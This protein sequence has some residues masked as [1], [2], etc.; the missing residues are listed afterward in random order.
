MNGFIKSFFK[1]T[2]LILLSL[3]ISYT[4]FMLVIFSISFGMDEMELVAVYTGVLI[5]SLALFG[6]LY[7]KTDKFEKIR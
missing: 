2:A 5:F 6:M 7:V 3:L 4:A 1:M